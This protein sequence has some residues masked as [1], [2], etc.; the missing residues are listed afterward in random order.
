MAQA[1]VEILE[2]SG[3]LTANEI[4]AQLQ[5]PGWRSSVNSVKYTVFYELAG[6]VQQ[7]KAGCFVVT[8]T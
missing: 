2:D 8:D 4:A 6:R 5:E 3:Q 7:T 1:I